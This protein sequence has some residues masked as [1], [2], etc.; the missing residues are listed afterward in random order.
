METVSEYQRIYQQPSKVRRLNIEESE[1][2]LPWN[3]VSTL[4]GNVE[5]LRQNNLKRKQ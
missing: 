1:E 3:K 4:R 2:E 5:D